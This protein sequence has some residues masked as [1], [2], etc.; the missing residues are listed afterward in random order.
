MEAFMNTAKRKEHEKRYWDR[1]LILYVGVLLYCLL[2][3]NTSSDR[4][5]LIIAGSLYGMV[6][7]TCFVK[8]FLYDEAGMTSG[9]LVRVLKYHGADPYV[10]FGKVWKR[11]LLTEGI[12]A[13]LLGASFVWHGKEPVVTLVAIGLVVVP[14][15]IFALIEKYFFYRMN[16]E[17]SRIV[18]V[19]VAGMVCIPLLVGTI[20][21]AVKGIVLLM[22]CYAVLS[23]RISLNQISQDESAYYVYQN[24]YLSVMV[25]LL[26]LLLVSRFYNRWRITKYISLVLLIGFVGSVGLSLYTEKQN[27][28]C[29]TDTQILCTEKGITTEY[30]LDEVEAICLFAEEEL[31][32][33][34]TLPGGK[35]LKLMGEE[36]TTTDA[37]GDS[38]ADYY[39]YLLKLTKQLLAQGAE[40]TVS[41]V[42]GVR[43]SMKN[44]SAESSS[45]VEELIQILQ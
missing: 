43:Q 36:I 28:V 42:E 16:H 39:D 11:L 17:I 21:L 12:M 8:Y 1:E 10:L 4:S 15:L 7:L 5:D 9:F 26:I 14:I 22:V 31:Q 18:R 32:Y 33:T 30:R 23:N 27:H 24:P 35:V 44:L 25:L 37:W 3:V 40:G 41:N 38:Y 29:V 34:L 45:S 13:A 19:V 2:G 6:L 20:F